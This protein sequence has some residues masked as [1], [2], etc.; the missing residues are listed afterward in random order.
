[1]FEI[2]EPQINETQDLSH[3]LKEKKYSSKKK[4]N[5]EKRKKKNY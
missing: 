1:M 4:K 5:K 2:S 3:E